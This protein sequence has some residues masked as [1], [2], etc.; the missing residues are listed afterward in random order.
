MRIL[1]QYDIMTLWYFFH[2]CH[3]LRYSVL[4]Y[5]ILYSIILDYI[6]CYLQTYFFIVS[7][8]WIVR[9]HSNDRVAHVT[10][11]YMPFRYTIKHNICVSIY[12]L[13]LIWLFVQDDPV[14]ST[15]SIVS[16]CA[17]TDVTNVRPVE[18][19]GHDWPL[20]YYS[21]LDNVGMVPLKDQRSR[22]DILKINLK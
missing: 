14:P 16:H 2:S 9:P 11:S 13:S 19:F 18:I 17:V 5:I 7:S 3:T 15:N 1:W 22:G 8:C 6:I 12:L 21:K 10:T 4:Y 20:V